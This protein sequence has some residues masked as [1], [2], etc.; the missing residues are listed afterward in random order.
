[1]N[2]TDLDTF[3]RV[4]E[5]G[6]LSRAATELGVPKST[7]SRRVTRLEDD[8]GVELLHRTPRSVAI[9]EHGKRLQTR[10]APALREIGEA[11]RSLADEETKPRGRLR[12]SA[13]YDMGNT[14]YFA[15]LLHSF[16]AEY[17]EVNVEI[18]LANRTVDLVEEGF[19]LTLRL[20]TGQLNAPGNLR[21]RLVA[22]LSVGVYAS[23]K[24]VEVHGRP[25]KPK[26]VEDHLVV[27]HAMAPKHLVPPV[28]DTPLEAC[29]SVEPAFV[30]NDFSLILSLV[31]AGGCMGLL[32]TFL[33]RPHLEA[34]E[35]ERLLPGEN[36]P[37]GAMSLLWPA[38]RHTAPRVRAFIDHVTQSTAA[39]QFIREVSPPEARSRRTSS[40]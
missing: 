37:Q 32:P 3:I 12:I 19:D 17:P 27:T 6:S 24:Y 26:D 15:E 23:P 40:R 35:L 16:R 11:E 33:A 22:R 31:L 28:A 5:T 18:V 25:L 29:P 10:C 20:H 1:M 13:P 30:A 14:R 4:A 38:S 7:V 2:L 39:G 34:G 21:T 8:L 9:T 36:P